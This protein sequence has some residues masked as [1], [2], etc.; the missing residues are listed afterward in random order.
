MS[1][2]SGVSSTENQQPPQTA[3]RTPAVMRSPRA[4]A[5][6]AFVLMA[7]A[8]VAFAPR[9]EGALRPWAAG[10]MIAGA[11]VWLRAGW[12]YD[13]GHGSTS[14]LHVERA[15]QPL[16]RWHVAIAAVAMLCLVALAA[17]QLVPLE[18]DISHHLQFALFVM[19]VGGLAVGVGGVRARLLAFAYAPRRLPDMAMLAAI[20]VFGLVLRLW[21]LGDGVQV[22]IDEMNTVGQLLTMWGT[23][24]RMLHQM[25]DINPYTW[26]YAYGQNTSVAW[27]G[28]DL[29]G[30]RA[31]SALTGALV[32]PATWL[33]MRTLFDRTAAL[34]AAVLVATFPFAVHFS[35]ISMNNI[36]DTLV[37]TLA[38]AFVAR[39]LRHNTRRDW[40]LAGVCLGL[41]QYFFEGGR[42]FFIP[43][44]VLWL[45]WLVVMGRKDALPNGVPWRGV[46]RAAIVT[47][48][49]AAPVYIT[50]SQNTDLA[51]NGRL[52]AN[53]FGGEYWRTL[54]TSTAGEGWLEGHLIHIRNAFLL[55][56]SLPESGPFYAGTQPFVQVFAVPFLL[57]GVAALLRRWRE[58]AVVLFFWPVSVAAANGLFLSVSTGSS[59][60]IVTASVLPMV[61]AVGVWALFRFL[62]AARI[63]PSPKLTEGGHVDS[64]RGLLRSPAPLQIAMWVTAL[65][66]ATA[67]VTYYFG[68]H[69]ASFNQTIRTYHDLD[70]AIFQAVAFEREQAEVHII[71]KGWRD[72]GYIDKLRYFLVDDPPSVFFF[73]SETLRAGYLAGLPAYLDQA[74]LV[75]PDDTA[76]LDLLAEVYGPRELI[77]ADYDGPP[78]KQFGLF[79][80]TAEER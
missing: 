41:S 48:V 27:F 25:N 80:V 40:T 64:G 30:L 61:M 10:M 6:T 37:G 66:L 22:L 42:L 18:N 13:A 58:P 76:T 69:L 79:Y 49:L 46:L 57:I 53:R 2:Q 19:A 23:D 75:E 1:V 4:L 73:T 3:R 60:Y 77:F 55:Y 33:L 51:L 31:V 5:L 38:I 56:V 54:L 14:P 43:L 15:E 7:G 67:Q 20:T 17:I 52:A 63:S 47:V 62:T 39:G 34:I 9:W 44:A 36:A 24:V 32:V 65:A 11:V 78:E 26:L 16:T 50:W 21:Q 68:P 12:V 71:S 72:P 8:A 45:G 28:R 35:R 70:D 59:R 74:F 29:F